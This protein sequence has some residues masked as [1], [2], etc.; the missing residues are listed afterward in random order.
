MYSDKSSF[1]VK[2]TSRVGANYEINH[3]QSD[4]LVLEVCCGNRGNHW[5][6]DFHVVS[7][8]LICISQEMFIYNKNCTI[9][10]IGELTVLVNQIEESSFNGINMMLNLSE[11][12][13]CAEWNDLNTSLYR[14]SI[15]YTIVLDAGF[16]V[17]IIVTWEILVKYNLHVDLWYYDNETFWMRLYLLC[18]RD[19]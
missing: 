14:L 18:T 11:K 17:Q 12:V 16:C 9:T 8:V 19:R 5:D 15:G 13:V 6:L 10:Y 3:V 2:V 4:S 7:L 1:T